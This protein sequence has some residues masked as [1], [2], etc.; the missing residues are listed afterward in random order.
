VRFV[1]IIPA[2]ALGAIACSG[3]LP[4]AIPNDNRLSGATERAGVWELTLDARD[5]GWRPDDGVDS[6]LTVQAF[7]LAD[8]IPRVPGPL[9]RVP[10][11]AEVRVTVINSVREGPLEFH[12]MAATWGDTI[13]LHVPNGERREVHFS[14]RT[15]GTYLYWATTTGAAFGDR[16][17]RDAQLTGAI[18]V[19][20]AG[21]APD[22][23]ERIFVI[24]MMDVL[25]DT[26]KPLAGQS[27]I[28]DLA[29]NGKSWPHT[30]PLRY[31]VGDTVRW[32]WLNGSQP[33]HPMHLHGFHFR[34]LS[35]GNGMTDTL[36]AADAARL[37][38]TEF[39]PPS[40][41]FQMDFVPTR[42]GRWLFHC[43]MVPH[44][45]PF[46][47][48]PDSVREHSLHG[49]AAAHAN[50][51]MSGLVLGV[52][53]VPRA[54]APVTAAEP[55]ASVRRL[56]L[57]AQQAPAVDSTP[58]A[59]GFVLQSDVE[60]A[61][62]SVEIPGTP[63]ILTRGE[64]VEITVVNRLPQHTNVHWH[65]MELDSYYD[66]VSGWS[67]ADSRRT[68]MVAPGDSFVVVFTPPRSGTFMYHTH[69]EEEPQ[70]QRGLFGP[71]LVLEP[72]ER[73]DPATDIVMIVGH[74]P[75]REDPL[76]PT[77]NGRHEPPPFELEAAPAYRLRL[78][79]ILGA[80]PIYL[81][82]LSADTLLVW[83]PLAKDGAD[84]PPAQ[85]AMQPAQAMIGVGET[86]D[87]RWRPGGVRNAE[88]RV[89]QAGRD[90]AAIRVPVRMRR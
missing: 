36:Y 25:P 72:G 43:H 8:A 85:R 51:A 44:I 20:A 42:V 54:D 19:D 28:F 35:K 4:Q 70:I 41:T 39:M 79:N 18:V 22:T 27:D 34:V 81:S 47:E 61:A 52:E 89:R 9:L 3:G 53:V 80:D 67:G 13:P 55:R 14:A 90:S 68:P 86:Y 30:E 12:G 76:E 65:G 73:Y 50:A 6:S 24:T 88:L 16:T 11:G 56:R 63:L 66:G 15:A 62:D 31:T 46:P 48:R 29:I 23:S 32:R 84:V 87:F 7:A 83:E 37:A 17:L 21:A 74:R 33:S 77:L 75:G 38:V 2:C 57:L 60:P 5:A 26:T 71:M 40:S 1:T 78:I 64:Q 58:P 59:R 10:V 49:D 82:L 69:M 45:T